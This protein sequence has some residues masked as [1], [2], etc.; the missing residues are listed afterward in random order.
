MPWD[1]QCLILIVSTRLLHMTRTCP[2][3]PSAVGLEHAAKRSCCASG[4]GPWWTGLGLCIGR[5]HGRRSGWLRSCCGGCCWRLWR[6]Q[7]CLLRR[8]RHGAGTL[9]GSKASPPRAGGTKRVSKTQSGSWRRLGLGRGWAE[10]RRAWS[11]TWIQ[12]PSLRRAA[13]ASC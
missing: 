4:L 5:L 13:W 11:G 3:L 8:S 9:L 6:R 12:P 7:P 2:F 1:M 10:Q